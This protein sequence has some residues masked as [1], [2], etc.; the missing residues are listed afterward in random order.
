MTTL[1]RPTVPADEPALNRLLARAFSADAD[2]PAFQ[3]QI[4]RWKYWEPRE[5]WPEPRAYVL[6]REGQI[7][8]HAGLWPVVITHPDGC[9]RGVHM[10][11]WAS[12]PESA[13]AGVSLLHRLTRTFSFVYSIGGSEMTREI[14]PKFGFKRVA[15]VLTWA[16]PLR[17]WRQIALHQQKDLRLPVRLARNLW[18]AGS[19]A[20]KSPSAW[21]AVQTAP[22]H[23]VR[24]PGAERNSSFFEYLSRCPAIRDLTFQILK[25]GNPVGFFALSLVQRQARV[26]GIWLDEP[27]TESWRRVFELAQDAALRSTDAC[28]IAAQ[29]IYD[30]SA[31]DLAGMRVRGETPVFFYRRDGNLDFRPLRFQFADNDSI[32]LAGPAPAFLC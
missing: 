26:I 17:P 12:V 11:D 23:L 8:A 9:E 13:G 5:D 32:F 3:G 4:L 6:E 15:E 16:R 1:F 24:G 29:G 21:R 7:V 10:I 31:M 19:P 30:P 28:E 14:L 18:W 27:G 25:D 2:S 22:G 20:R